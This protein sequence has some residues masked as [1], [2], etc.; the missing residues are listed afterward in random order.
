MRTLCILATL[1][2]LTLTRPTLAQDAL[3]SD[4]QARELAETLE[5]ADTLIVSRGEGRPRLYTLAPLA[6]YSTSYRATQYLSVTRL[7]DGVP[8]AGSE[9]PTH[10]ALVTSTVRKVMD[11]RSFVADSVFT[12]L[13]VAENTDAT[14]AANQGMRA[15][16]APLEG[17]S[18]VRTLSERGLP[19]PHDDVRTKPAADKDLAKRIAQIALLPMYILPDEPVAPGAVWHARRDFNEDNIQQTLILSYTLTDANDD[20]ISLSVN[21]RYL[22]EEQT[23]PPSP[24]M[25]EMVTTITDGTGSILGELTIDRRSGAPTHGFV[26][27]D[28]TVNV[29]A[30]SPET[31]RS[32]IEQRLFSEITISRPEGEDEAAS[33]HPPR[34]SVPDLDRVIAGMP[35]SGSLLLSSGVG[36]KSELRY[37]PSLDAARTISVTT[38]FELLDY[39]GGVGTMEQAAIPDFEQTIALATQAAPGN[40]TFSVFTRVTDAGIV[41]DPAFDARLLQTFDVG[42]KRLV[43]QQYNYTLT[44]RGEV[45]ERIGQEANASRIRPTPT[46]DIEF[47]G[48]SCVLP[49]APLGIGAR[50]RTL[51]KLSHLTGMTTH[52]LRDFELVAITDDTF[53]VKIKHSKIARLDDEKNLT[54]PLRSLL[55]VCEGEL[56]YD[57]ALGRPVEGSMVTASWLTLQMVT[58]GKAQMLQQAGA[59][60]VTIELAQ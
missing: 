22:L 13:G 52:V 45:L 3:L 19:I 27:T 60:T 44:T 25:P 28:A 17:M 53:T 42:I 47:A 2:A 18:S 46:A 12:E 54:S 51:E 40:G 6:G 20:T 11:D 4:Q 38:K 1:A 21:G 16:I 33:T 34:P 41:E 39:E 8:M 9:L 48:T 29:T 55:A 37:T 35:D 7:F 49:E 10:T 15:L 58:L 57:R 30:K 5:H 50:W 56:T 43:G 31:S 26:R 36:D 14:D 32:T 24:Q 59:T 23:L